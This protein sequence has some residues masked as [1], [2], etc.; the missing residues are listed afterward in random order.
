MCCAVWLASKSSL[1]T[2]NVHRATEPCCD[3]VLSLRQCQQLLI[4]SKPV[5]LTDNNVH[6]DAARHCKLNSVCATSVQ[7]DTAVDTHYRHD[8]QH[9]KHTQTHC[10]ES[11]SL[12]CEQGT[13]DTHVMCDSLSQTHMC[14]RTLTDTA[15]LSLHV[16]IQHQCR[17]L[18]RF[19]NKCCATIKLKTINLLSLVSV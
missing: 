1:T 16:A 5:S 7:T 2:L 6:F 9:I 13:V 15:L 4:V 8:R 18:H 10:S 11:R 14:H 3:A 19:V 12:S 17:M